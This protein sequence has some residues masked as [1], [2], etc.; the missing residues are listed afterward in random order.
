MRT[1]LGTSLRQA[2][3][4]EQWTRNGSDIPTMPVADFPP[5]LASEI[6]RWGKVVRDANLAL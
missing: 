4:R 1:E 6:A 3:I 5:F 2:S